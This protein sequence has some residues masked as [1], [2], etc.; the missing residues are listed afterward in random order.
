MTLAQTCCCGRCSYIATCYSA[1]TGVPDVIQFSETNGD[2]IPSA[3]LSPPKGITID[4]DT[5][6]VTLNSASAV[7]SGGDRTVTTWNITVDIN[8]EANTEYPGGFETDCRCDDDGTY[9]DIPA[10]SGTA[11]FTG[12]MV[13]VCLDD[14]SIS[15]GT[16]NWANQT[17]PRYNLNTDIGTCPS[18]TLDPPDP[19]IRMDLKLTNASTNWEPGSTDCT[20]LATK[21]YDA[22]FNFE[23]QNNGGCKTTTY[24]AAATLTIRFGWS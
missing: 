2:P 5:I 15:A 1:G 24:G 13:Y 3:F 16:F 21:Y 8:Y 22:V 18:G 11:T 20:S 7:R 19:T 23:L 10:W 12:N 4:T 6:T 9:S 17:A 14:D